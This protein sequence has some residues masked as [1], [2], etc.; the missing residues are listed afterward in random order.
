M[1][2]GGFFSAAVGCAWPFCAIAIGGIIEVL[3]KHDY[4]S[5]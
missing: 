4:V 2:L 5:E 3:G 1:F